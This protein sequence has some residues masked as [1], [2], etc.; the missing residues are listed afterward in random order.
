M[1]K[2]SSPPPLASFTLTLLHVLQRLGRHCCPASKAK[3][4][5][6]CRTWHDALATQFTEV[7]LGPGSPWPST[8][9]HMHQSGTAAVAGYDT[10][11]G[12]F[13]AAHSL[14]VT[15]SSSRDY[16][17]TYTQVLAHDGYGFQGLP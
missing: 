9:Q 6:V 10:V 3:L 11:M 13:P 2:P 16:P 14:C 12:S 5:V 4:R 15:A 17:A 8:E 1:L 7:F